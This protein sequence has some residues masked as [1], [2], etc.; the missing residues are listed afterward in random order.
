MS[1][2]DTLVGKLQKAHQSLIQDGVKPRLAGTIIDLAIEDEDVFTQLVEYTGCPSGTSRD[3]LVDSL[4]YEVNLHL[5][6]FGC[7]PSKQWLLGWT[8]NIPKT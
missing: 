4:E 3:K 6:I 1:N 8:N 7:I 2:F 5:R